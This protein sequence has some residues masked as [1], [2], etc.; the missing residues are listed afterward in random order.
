MND[1]SG[2]QVTQLNTICWNQKTGIT[3]RRQECTQTRVGQI[4]RRL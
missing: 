2:P 4:G 1:L 3:S